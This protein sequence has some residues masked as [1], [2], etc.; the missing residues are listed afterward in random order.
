MLKRKQRKDDNFYTS[1]FSNEISRKTEVID[2]SNVINFNGFYGQ[3]NGLNKI[4]YGGSLN[5]IYNK[6]KNVNICDNLGDINHKSKTFETSEKNYQ[7]KDVA[8]FGYIDENDSLKSFKSIST[9]LMTN[10]ELNESGE[11]LTNEN[12]VEEENCKIIKKRIDEF[13]KCE[14]EIDYYNDNNKK[15]FKVH[16]AELGENINKFNLSL[17]QIS[18][19]VINFLRKNHMTSYKEIYKEVEDIKGLIYKQSVN[20]PNTNKQK[21]D[22]KNIKRRIYDV[23]NVFKELNLFKLFRSDKKNITIISNV[24]IN[25]DASIPFRYSEEDFIKFRLEFKITQIKS[26]LNKFNSLTNFIENNKA[27]NVL[28]STFQNTDLNERVYFPCFL[29]KIE[30]KFAEIC[31]IKSNSI[32]EFTNS[33]EFSQKELQFQNQIDTSVFIDKNESNLDEINQI[34]VKFDNCNRIFLKFIDDNLTTSKCE[35]ISDFPF[36]YN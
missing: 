25:K 4:I 11:L 28:S 21:K 24:F 34:K 33:Q 5:L 1:N 2:F 12:T 6:D 8:N 30:K 18:S 32:N 13:Q 22:S 31:I 17:K 9:Q 16:K 3:F 29:F 23:L 26:L 27:K 7:Y 36:L 35:I 19:I 14:I 10:L 15:L 20:T